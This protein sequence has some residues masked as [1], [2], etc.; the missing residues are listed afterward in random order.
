MYSPHY[1]I[2]RFISPCAFPHPFLS[3]KGTVAWDIPPP[4]FSSKVPTWDPDLYPKILKNLVSNSWLLQ[5]KFDSPL[6]YT[7]GSKIL[8]LHFA[9]GIQ[10]FPL[11]FAA[12]RCDSRCILHWRVRFY[13]CKLQRGVE[14]YRCTM[15]RGVES[16][17]CIMQQRVKS[18]SCIMQQRIK[19]YRC[20]KQRRVKSYRFMMQRGVKSKNFR[21]LHRPLKR[22]SCKKSL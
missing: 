14:S 9:A 2:H 20:M 15:Q 3:F 16:Y 11:H 4:F 12:E 6:H 8:L 1:I 7:A 10:I 22:Q 21:R 13:H 5:L 18:Y 17:H 19:S